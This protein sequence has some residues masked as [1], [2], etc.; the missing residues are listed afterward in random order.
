MTRRSGPLARPAILVSVV[1]AV[2]AS[3]VTVPASAAT[4]AS[5][6]TTLRWHRCT[7][8]DPMRGVDCGTLTVPLSWASPDGRT[9][10][11][12]F[13]V[14]T[15]TGFDDE[16]LG[17]LAYNPG[18]PGGG[19]AV[20]DF[21]SVLDWLPAPILRRFDIVAMDPRGTGGSGPRIRS[22]SGDP[23]VTTAPPATGPV[24]WSTLAQTYAAKVVPYAQGCLARNAGAAPYVGTWYVIRDLDALREA[25]DEDELNFWGMSYGTNVGRAYAQAFPARISGLVLDG[26][27][28]PDSTIASYARDHIGGQRDGLATL[29]TLL[30][31][32]ARARM[33]QVVRALDERSIAVPGGGTV[34]RWDFL[35]GIIDLASYEDQL[36][37]VTRIIRLAYTALFSADGTARGK[38]A[39][40]LD[41]LVGPATDSTSNPDFNYINC[42][43][44]PDRPAVS[45]IAATAAAAAAASNGAAGLAALEEGF[46]CL[47]L[48]ADLGRSLPPLTQPLR[49]AIAP[50]V[51][52]AVGDNRT[53]WPGARALADAF[54]G[55]S[56]ITYDGTQHVVYGGVSTCVD[57]IVT[58][59]LVTGQ[60]PARDREGPFAS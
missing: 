40:G 20:E 5:Y 39:R 14:H 22:C 35:G 41:R 49:L 34:T 15:A 24:D 58:R 46:Q 27:I 6:D 33:T 50:V 37:T 21:D 25:L 13:A 42:S 10:P 45:Q 26:G 30:T 3:L 7:E 17:I 59:F 36:P 28:A 44:M 23:W 52:N 29:A 53:P 60:T 16:Y 38:A 51:I 47:G 9:I 11:V 43:D 32:T 2:L 57:R 12:S 19:G 48:P 18:G 4:P 54:V 1:C 55:A 56:L 31:S 8:M